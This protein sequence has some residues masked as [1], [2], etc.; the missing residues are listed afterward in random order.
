MAVVKH[1]TLRTWLQFSV[2]KLK[3]SHQHLFLKEQEFISSL[4]FTCMT[5][6]LL[7]CSIL[8]LILFFQA[9]IHYSQIFYDAKLCNSSGLNNKS[10]ALSFLLRVWNER[11]NHLYLILMASLPRKQTICQI[12][13]SLSIW[14]AS[15]CTDTCIFS[16]S[17]ALS[18][19]MTRFYSDAP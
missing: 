18:M 12:S 15:S 10:S 19:R 9:N 14:V 1:L 4:F 17:N 11:V 6:F 8:I 13:C 3:S 5:F 2:C 16:P 7:F